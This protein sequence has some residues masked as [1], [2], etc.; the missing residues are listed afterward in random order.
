MQDLCGRGYIC[1]RSAWRKR[2]I[3]CAVLCC[4]VLSFFE[5]VSCSWSCGPTIA[6][7]EQACSEFFFSSNDVRLPASPRGLGVGTRFVA[8][9]LPIHF[10]RESGKSVVWLYEAR[11]KASMVFAQYI[12]R[13]IPQA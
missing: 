10:V 7:A 5:S 3:A 13:S 11:R 9:I 6:V 1:G 2:K 12:A 4:A 8:C